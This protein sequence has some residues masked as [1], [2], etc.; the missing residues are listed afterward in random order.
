MSKH[1][2]CVAIGS[3]LDLGPVSSPWNLD[4]TAPGQISGNFAQ[5]CLRALVAG[6]QQKGQ[7][8]NKLS[9]PAVEANNTSAEHIQKRVIKIFLP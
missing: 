3:E 8:H 9:I 2:E 4:S 6:T 7:H 1:W 5:L